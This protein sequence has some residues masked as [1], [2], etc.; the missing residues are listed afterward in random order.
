MLVRRSLSR[1]APAA[2]AAH[3][4]TQWLYVVH[5]VPG[6]F[7]LIFLSSVAVLTRNSTYGDSR[8]LL[9]PLSR[10]LLQMFIPNQ[11]GRGGWNSLHVSSEK[12]LPS[13]GGGGHIIIVCYRQEQRIGKLR[14][15]RRCFL[16]DENPPSAR[17]KR[18]RGKATTR[19]GGG[20]GRWTMRTCS[21]AHT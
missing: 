8:F 7:S 4:H 9:L 6:L 20:G 15:D 13:G 16:L 21:A 5:T 11:S 14:H 3:S 10:S 17:R 12:V 1:V 18:G 19:G 2:A